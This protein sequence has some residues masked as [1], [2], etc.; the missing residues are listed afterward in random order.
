MVHMMN[1]AD[2]WTIS[3]EAVHIVR[4]IADKYAFKEC[5]NGIGEDK[6]FNQLDIILGDEAE[7]KKVYINC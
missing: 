5:I 1:D 7:I 2:H 3:G 4:S 6:G